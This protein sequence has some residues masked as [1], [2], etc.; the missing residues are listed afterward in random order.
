MATGGGVP[1]AGPTGGVAAHVRL[2]VAVET[3]QHSALARPLDYLAAAALEPGTL[4]RV[5]LGRRMVTGIVWDAQD[6]AGAVGSAALKPVAE[7]FDSLPP[8]R[9]AW[10]RLVE[11]AAGYYQRGLGELGLAVLPPEL[12]KIDAAA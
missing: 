9:Q 5:P 1:E 10:R 7:V 6:E 12:R 4:V 2:Q 3:P 8:L 11:F